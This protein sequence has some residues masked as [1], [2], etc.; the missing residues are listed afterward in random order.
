MKLKKTMKKGISLVMTLALMFTLLLNVGVLEPKAASSVITINGV[1]LQVDTGV[2]GSAA[3]Y[4]NGDD[5]T[6]GLTGSESDWNAKYE[7]MGSRTRLTLKNL[8]LEVDGITAIDSVTGIYNDGLTLVLEGTNVITDLSETNT[9]PIIETYHTNNKSLSISGDGTLTINDEKTKT[10]DTVTCQNFSLL[11]KAKLTLNV[12]GSGSNQR[13]IKTTGS[14]T[15]GDNANL[16][17]N[18]AEG[19]ANCYGIYNTNANSGIMVTDNA[20]VSINMADGTDTTNCDL[21]AIDT[22]GNVSLNT[23]GKVEINVGNACN[24]RGVYAK[25]VTV[26]NGQLIV[27]VAQGNSQVY[28]IQTRNSGNISVSNSGVIDVKIAQ[29]AETGVQSGATKVGVYSIGS[30]ELSGQSKLL[31][32]TGVTN[33]YTKGLDCSKGITMSGSDSADGPLIEIDIPVAQ[34][35]Y[36]IEVGSGN[37][38]MANN[39]TININ[40]GGNTELSGNHVGVYGSSGTSSLWTMTGNAQVNVDIG[41][42]SSSIL[43]ISM[44]RN[45]TMEDDSKISV[46]CG[47]A[48]LIQGILI[49]NNL[50]MS[51]NTS[52]EVTV[53]ET[54]ML[55]EGVDVK[56]LTMTDNASLTTTV[57]DST[58]GTMGC[59]GLRMRAASS[60][61]GNASIKAT[62]GNSTSATNTA[63]IS[64]DA[65]F[66][67]NGGTVEAI[68]VDGNGQAFKAL[69]VI[70]SPSTFI[71]KAGATSGAATEQDD[72]AKTTAATYTGNEYALIKAIVTIDRVDIA[73]IDTPAHKQTPD[74]V[75]TTTTE[76]V[77]SNPAII[78]SPTGEIIG[79]ED[80]V[81]TITI[82][83]EDGYVFSG[84]VKVY[85]GTDE[86]PVTLNDGVIKATYNTTATKARL[87]SFESPSDITDVENGTALSAIELPDELPIGTSAGADKA[88]VTWDLASV[89][90]DPASTDEQT[91][92]V[93]GTLTLPSYVDAN[94][95]NNLNV[96]VNVTVNAATPTTEAPTTEEPTTQE[97]T[98]QEP[99]TQEPTT[100]APTTQEPTTQAP[101]TQAPT[102][103][104]PTTQAP[105]TGSMTDTEAPTTATTAATTE[106]PD[107]SDANVKTGDN[108]PLAMLFVLMLLAGIGMVVVSKKKETI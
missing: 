88:T 47:N 75:A 69:P 56:S 106:A 21:H 81:G 51:D 66:T 59:L 37:S 34:N 12:G 10:T 83:A 100:Q 35:S 101:T 61:S 45:V 18:V 79:G 8:N 94:G 102:T 103:Q 3:Y 29:E 11:G 77:K 20:S 93:R 62:I 44:D 64:N 26:S 1:N 13:I 65:T 24:T 38:T 27:N 108:A 32:D 98:T 82:K 41:N 63:A 57:G 89:N 7:N 15:I 55:T 72:T 73:G 9:N 99:T 28:G 48:Q 49:S 78:W 19:G 30:V 25:D 14:V 91:F 80:Y 96:R 67:I 33:I 31:I 50:D 90:Y 58:T 68:S 74:S 60:V 97:P 17:I 107:N 54:S 95:L 6:S 76:G 2:T 46:K 42:A 85:Y 86:L 5:T 53:G 71:V 40:I 70:T 105:N 87:L 16:E 52:V 39:S 104:E 84:D 36:A 23:T 4:K 43:G 92:T 22:A